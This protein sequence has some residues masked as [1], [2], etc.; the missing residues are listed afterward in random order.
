MKVNL[1]S[2]LFPVVEYRYT[3]PTH[4]QL[5]L[6]ENSFK[7]KL[8]KGSQQGSR[9]I[10]VPHLYSRTGSK[11]EFKLTFKRKCEFNLSILSCGWLWFAADS[12]SSGWIRVTA[13]SILRLTRVPAAGYNLRLIPS[14]GWLWVA[15][16]SSS[17]GS[18]R[19]AA[20]SI[21]LEADSYF[22]ITS[23]IK[24][25]FCKLHNFCGLFSTAWFQ[26]HLIQALPA[27]SR[28]LKKLEEAWGS[29]KI[30]TATNSSCSD[31]LELRLL[32]RNLQ[33]INCL[34]NFDPDAPDTTKL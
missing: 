5:Q 21:R 22:N 8:Q 33:S 25:L 26:L 30:L 6:R 3:P 20:D 10:G 24:D 2:S 31:S 15:A 29:F 27:T 18:I 23:K 14:C 16:D 19:V 4:T 34:Q 11:E 12:S 1:N 32:I 9:N 7:N 17:S 28:T 13:G